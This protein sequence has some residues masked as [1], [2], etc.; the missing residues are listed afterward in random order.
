RLSR[1]RKVVFPHSDVGALDQLMASVSCA[2]LRFVVVESLYSMDGDVGPLAEFDALC[3]RRGAL[4]I[5]DE[6]HAVGV[7]GARGSGLI[8]AA[9]LDPTSCVSVNPAGKALGASGA[10]V[11]GPARL[12]PPSLAGALDASLTIVGEEPVRR[13]RLLARATYFRSRLRRL[14]LS[15]S[16]EVTQIVPVIIGDNLRAVAVADQLQAEGFD[17]RAIRPPAVPVGTA[18]LRIS[19]NAALTE[20]TLD[21]FSDALVAALTG[22][23]CFAVSS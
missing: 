17:V 10:F 8:E 9:G 15:V 2:G 1:A 11:A 3:R 20:G 14:G 5:V 4:L 6:A 19:L 23:Q 13:E 18:R 22:H 7:F 21:R 12:P 16:D